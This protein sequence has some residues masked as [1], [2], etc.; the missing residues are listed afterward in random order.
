MLIIWNEL[1]PATTLAD[2]TDMASVR[3]NGVVEM[4]NAFFD[5]TLLRIM[6]VNCDGLRKR[7]KQLELGDILKTLRVGLCVATE[8]HLRKVDL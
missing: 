4:E 1:G 5:K 6:T 7:K 2:K 3:P 8:S